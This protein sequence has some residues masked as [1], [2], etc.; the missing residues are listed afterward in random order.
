MN[1][2]AKEITEKFMT[3]F[4]RAHFNAILIWENYYLEPLPNKGINIEHIDDLRLR[5]A[6]WCCHGF[7]NE[8]LNEVVAA[9]YVRH[10]FRL[11][12]CIISLISQV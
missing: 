3:V 1:S 2:L 6:K 10:F 11:K 4:V 9:F 8:A 12:F 5:G 7:R